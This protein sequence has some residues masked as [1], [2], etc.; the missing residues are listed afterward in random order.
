VPRRL[1]R[2]VIERV[3]RRKVRADRDW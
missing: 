1:M 2:Q 3:T